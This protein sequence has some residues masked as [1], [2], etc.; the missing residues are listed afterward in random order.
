ML[1]GVL[2][3]VNDLQ[4]DVRY[5]REFLNKLRGGRRRVVNAISKAQKDLKLISKPGPYIKKIVPSIKKSTL[6]YGKGRLQQEIVV[7]IMKNKEFNDPVYKDPLMSAAENND[8]FTFVLKGNSWES[9]PVVRLDFA[10]SAGRLNMWGLGIKAYREKLKV[11]IPRKNSKLYNRRAEKASKYWA[12]I[13]NEAG[14]RFKKTIKG[15]ISL[16]GAKAPFWKILDSGT[17]PSLPSDRGGYP[18]PDNVETN[19]VHKAETDVKQYAKDLFLQEKIRFEEYINSINPAMQEANNVLSQLDGLINLVGLGVK[20]NKEVEKRFGSLMQYIDRN[21]LDI[22]LDKIR[23]G[24]L[25]AG[26]VDITLRGSPRRVRPS[27]SRLS[28]YLGE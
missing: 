14:S 2:D 13:Y 4:S 24:L 15:R 3:Y 7:A 28:S 23:K 25:V 22:A 11:K 20:E 6:N 19:F 9:I 10:I 26:T 1:R 8:I 17:P 18:T 5:T 21:K 16:S 27:V 12:K